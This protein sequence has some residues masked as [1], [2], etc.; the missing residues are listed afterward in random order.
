MTTNTHGAE[1]HPFCMPETLDWL[2]EVGKANGVKRTEV[3]ATMLRFCAKN[4]RPEELRL[5]APARAER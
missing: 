4:Y 2:D 5:T 3:A 1:V